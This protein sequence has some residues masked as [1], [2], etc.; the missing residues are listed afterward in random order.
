MLD[1][2]VLDR[3]VDRYRKGSRTLAALCAQYGVTI[4]NAH[5]ASADAMA[6]VGVLL[7]LGAC[8]RGAAAMP[9]RAPSTKRRSDGTGNGLRDTTSG[10]SARA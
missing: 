2:V 3:H 6:S 10:A 5:D 7:A 1:A 4:E 9:N 8:L